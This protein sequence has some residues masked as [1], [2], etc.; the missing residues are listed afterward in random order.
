MK[1]INVFSKF[2]NV[3]LITSK[4]S[5]LGNLSLIMFSNFCNL[6][7][8]VWMLLK[9]ICIFE[10]E[11][12]SFIKLQSHSMKYNLIFSGIHQRDNEN[13]N[14]ETVL[15][16]FL[17][18]ELGITNA[19]EIHFQNVHRLSKRTDGKPRVF[20]FQLQLFFCSIVTN[21]TAL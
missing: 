17:T 12:E 21:G 13:E 2:S 16:D 14:T 15:K 10:F 11:R 19:N 18:H 4:T 8:I 9:S 20:M 6:S 1:T 5:S 3:L 7:L